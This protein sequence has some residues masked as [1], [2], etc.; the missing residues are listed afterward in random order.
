MAGAPAAWLPA[1]CRTARNA[2]AGILDIYRQDFGVEYKQDKSPV[3]IADLN[4]DRL[5]TAEL[6]ELTP[7]IPVLSEE[8]SSNRN[9]EERAGWRTYWLVDPLDGTKGFIR[10]NDFFTVNIALIEDH[11][12]VLGVVFAPATNRLYYAAQGHGAFSQNGDAEP[13]AI[14]VRDTARARPVIAV[15]REHINK[16]TRKLIEQLGEHELIR[17][18]SSLKCCLVADGS[19]DLYLRVGPTCEWD[20]GASQCVLEEAGGRLT[21]CADRPLRYNTKESLINPS[22]VAYAPAA[23]DWRRYVEGERQ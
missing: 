21:D 22:F 17:A 4:A 19:A 3:T 20:T 15:S 23:P 2:G 14:R 10:K 8:D 6:G 18:D 11:R 7:D 13:R 1:V 16:P 5:I 9:A 12:P